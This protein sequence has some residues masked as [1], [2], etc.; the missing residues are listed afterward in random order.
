MFCHCIGK[1]QGSDI[2]GKI[3]LLNP[4]KIFIEHSFFKD[5]YFDYIEIHLISCYNN[6]IAISACTLLFNLKYIVIRLSWQYSMQ[7]FLYLYTNSF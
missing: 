6:P 3:Y 1:Y 2:K 4:V 5:T 7:S